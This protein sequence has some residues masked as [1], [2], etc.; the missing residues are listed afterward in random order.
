MKISTVLCH[1]VGLAAAASRTKAPSG[2]LVVGVNQT[3][4]TVSGAVAALTNTTKEQIIFIQPGTYNEQVYIN[5]EGP[6]TIYGYTEDDMT[7]TGNTVTIQQGRSQA[8]VASNDL[9]ATLRAWSSNFK[10]YNV[11]L[12]NTYGQGSQALALSAEVTVC[13]FLLITP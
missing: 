12:K 3:Y 9:T 7:Y 5:I 10:L 4:T 13:S 1:L 8:T 2:A 6:L 11:N